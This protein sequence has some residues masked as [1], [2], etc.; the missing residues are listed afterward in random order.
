[1]V[2]ARVEEGE[3]GWRFYS[4]LHR[5]LLR[6]AGRVPDEWLTDIRRMLAGGDL[7]QVPDR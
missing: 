3:Q 4:G 6:V 2:D 1:M 5:L 7:V